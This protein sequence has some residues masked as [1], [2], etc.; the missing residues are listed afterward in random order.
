MEQKIIINI[1]LYNFVYFWM[2]RDVEVA[3]IYV[4]TGHYAFAVLM[5][6]YYS[7]YHFVNRSPKVAICVLLAP[8]LTHDS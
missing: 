6:Y 8:V 1:F 5:G 3:Y 2:K 4:D 7:V